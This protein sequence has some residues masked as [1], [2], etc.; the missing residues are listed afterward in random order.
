M[1][2]PSSKKRIPLGPT[3]ETVR[4]NFVRLRGAMQYKELSE[5]LAQVGRPI[6]PLG[7]RRIEAGERRVDADDLMALA[8]VFGV[9]TNALLLPHFV[10]EREVEVTGGRRKYLQW[11]L[12]AWAEGKTALDGDEESVQRYRVD[13]LPVYMEYG[14][15]EATR[16][17]LDMEHED[18]PKSLQELRSFIADESRRRVGYP[19]DAA[20][21]DEQLSHLLG[22]PKFAHLKNPGRNEG[23]D[24]DERSEL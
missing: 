2:P 10:Y 21:I 18:L 11:G 23:R 13:G 12:W 15:T 7:L 4:E 17:L 6:P 20:A 14:L 9:N 3:G 1:N 16:K 24:G 8:M 22:I 19:Y 5:R